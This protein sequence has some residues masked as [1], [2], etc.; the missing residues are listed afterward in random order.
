[1]TNSHRKPSRGA[2]S[3]RALAAVA[4]VATTAVVLL[5][6]AATPASALMYAV[7]N[8]AGVC[9]IE[10]L[11]SATGVITGTYLWHHHHL[12][13]ATKLTLTVK[14]PEGVRLGTIP[15]SPDEGVT[16][17]MAMSRRVIQMRVKS[18]VFPLPNPGNRPV[19]SRH[20][21]CL[22]V[23]P[24]ITGID[25]ADPIF[26][27]IDVDQAATGEIAA[28]RER[29][30]ELRAI[31]AGAPERGE[32][33]GAVDRESMVDVI[34]QLEDLS[35]MMLE[36][37]Q[38]LGGEKARLNRSRQT[39]E[40]TFTRIWVCA[41]LLIVCSSLSVWAQFRWLGGLIVKKKLI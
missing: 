24:A 18:F 14:S 38:N 2:A 30:A 15:L 22:E 11:E 25:P 4:L 39:S 19:S 41:I 8:T 1:M 3:S 5:S 29:A 28:E 27:T 40:S 34:Q 37:E 33:G 13:A 9:F 6:A 7:T 32:G 10:E 31:A 12:N 35:E 26:L 20:S 17:D 16:A 23:V 21:V 36:V